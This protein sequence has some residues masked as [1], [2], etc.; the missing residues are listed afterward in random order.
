MG[1]A[2]TTDARTAVTA[3]IPYDLIDWL[4]IYRIWYFVRSF[5]FFFAWTASKEKR[6][7]FKDWVQACNLDP[8]KA[9]SRPQKEP[10]NAGSMLAVVLVIIKGTVLLKA[11]DGI[12]SH[13]PGAL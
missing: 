6:I 2:A 4:S 8:S 5:P 7:F 11:R 13:V 10:D 1:D 12:S 9:S 3:T